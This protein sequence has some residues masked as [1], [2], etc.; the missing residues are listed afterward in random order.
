MPQHKLVLEHLR[1]PEKDHNLTG[2]LKTQ[3][4]PT[5]H[6]DTSPPNEFAQQWQAASPSCPS[7]PKTP[8][9]KAKQTKN[10][11]M[12]SYTQPDKNGVRSGWD[13]FD[14]YSNRIE[15]RKRTRMWSRAL[16]AIEG[17]MRPSDISPRRVRNLLIMEYRLP[18]VIWCI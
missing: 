15:F 18:L 10:S 12:I 8:V 3:P 13:V 1:C 7:A 5:R 17:L 6:W 16:L 14:S 11:A 4:D 9:R 2:G